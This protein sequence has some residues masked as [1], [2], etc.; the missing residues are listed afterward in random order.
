MDGEDNQGR[1]S[2][3]S[4]L[5]VCLADNKARTCDDLPV[6]YMRGYHGV[7]SQNSFRKW[8]SSGTQAQPKGVSPREDQR[9]LPRLDYSLATYKRGKQ[10]FVLPLLQYDA[11]EDTYF[12]LDWN[13]SSFEDEAADLLNWPKF[14]AERNNLKPSVLAAEMVEAKQRKLTENERNNALNNEKYLSDYAMSDKDM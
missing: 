7:T 5:D 14:F 13:Q 2:Q 6:Y 1:P 10:T 4:P 3:V 12:K 9:L 11:S 8:P